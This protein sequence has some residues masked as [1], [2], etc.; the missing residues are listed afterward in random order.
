M[1]TS[2]IVIRAAS[3]PNSMSALGWALVLETVHL[4]CTRIYQIHVE[5]CNQSIASLS[6][7]SGNDVS[8][9]FDHK[10]GTA[11]CDKF[12]SGTCLYYNIAS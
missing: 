4:P 6:Q 11:A 3:S 2:M 5:S 1:Q 10:S 12:L 8:R 9:C 7:N